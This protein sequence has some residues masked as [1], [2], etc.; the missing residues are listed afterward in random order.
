[1]QKLINKIYVLL[2]NDPLVENV[3]RIFLTIQMFVF[4]ISTK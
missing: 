3:L 4:I 2:D 1:M